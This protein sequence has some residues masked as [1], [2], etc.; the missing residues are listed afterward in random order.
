MPYFVDAGRDV[1]IENFTDQP[2]RYEPI[3]AYDY[4]KWRLAQ[5]Y[6][7]DTYIEDVEIK[8]EGQQYISETT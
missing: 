3:K 8:K 4:L 6:D 7:D 1:M 5:S 2:S